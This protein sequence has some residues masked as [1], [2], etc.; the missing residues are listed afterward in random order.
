MTFPNIPGVRAPNIPGVR[1]KYQSIE[2]L[3]KPRLAHD[4][5]R[6]GDAKQ[7]P[8]QWLADAIQT[9]RALCDHIEKIEGAPK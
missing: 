7:I 1:A 9:I 5:S 8:E 6:L 2:D 3:F 4:I